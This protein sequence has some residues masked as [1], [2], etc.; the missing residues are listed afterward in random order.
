VR[1]SSDYYPSIGSLLNSFC[2]RKII[3]KSNHTS[4]TGINIDRP[5]GTKAY[6]DHHDPEVETSGKKI[7]RPY[8]TFITKPAILT[9]RVQWIVSLIEFKQIQRNKCRRH[10]RYK[11]DS[12]GKMC[13]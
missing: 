12:N 10:G 2:P 11:I 5:E 1:L 13:K 6:C 4:I 3:W 8:G 7:C 9:K